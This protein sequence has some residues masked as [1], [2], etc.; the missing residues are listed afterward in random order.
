MVAQLEQLGR[1]AHADLA[2]VHLRPN[3]GG[4]LPESERGGDVLGRATRCLGQVA[5]LPSG[6][7]EP[8][9]ARGPSVTVRSFLSP[10]SISAASTRSWSVIVR[11]TH[12][13]VSNWALT[14][15][16]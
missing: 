13:T 11:M 1:L 7:D 15:A 8:E 3:A 9:V 4:E 6:L 12:G 16:A 5:E 10:F 14:A 2:G